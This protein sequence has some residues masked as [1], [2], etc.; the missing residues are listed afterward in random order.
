MIFDLTKLME[1]IDKLAS[2]K[3]GLAIIGMIVV[4]NMPIPV[5]LPEGWQG[6]AHIAKVLGIAAIAIT[7]I[8]CQFTLDHGP[9]KPESPSNGS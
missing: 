6:A 7:G 9:S 8:L 3:A 2:K 5:E 1:I 4:M